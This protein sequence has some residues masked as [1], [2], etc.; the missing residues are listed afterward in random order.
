MKALSGNRLSPP[1]L[2]IAQYFTS[3]YPL[4][5]ISSPSIRHSPAPLADHPWWAWCAQMTIFYIPAP[6]Y[7]TLSRSFSPSRID[8]F[9]TKEINWPQC[10]APRTNRTL[11]QNFSIWSSRFLHLYSWTSLVIFSKLIIIAIK[12]RF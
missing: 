8:T 11:G 6:L 3:S 7:S 12:Y 4:A 10:A 2:V 5:A 9:K 1:S